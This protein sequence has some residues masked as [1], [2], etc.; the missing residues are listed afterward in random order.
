MT[1]LKTI[2]LDEVENMTARKILIHLDKNE[3]CQVGEV[4]KELSLSAIRGQKVIDFLLSCGFI[5]HPENSP[6][7]QLNV[8]LK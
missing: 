4:L 1:N 8:N 3:K 5:K 2:A 6:Y 7:I